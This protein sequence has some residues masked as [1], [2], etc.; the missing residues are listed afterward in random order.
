MRYA[1]PKVA[2]RQAFGT[3]G[4]TLMESGTYGK[5]IQKLDSGEPFLGGNDS[6]GGIPIADVLATAGLDFACLD[7]MFCAFDWQ[8][9]QA[10]ARAALAGGMDPVIRLPSFPWI[11]GS[12]DHVF[13]EAARAFGIGMNGVCLSLNTPDQ[14]ARL[15]EIS[16]AWQKNIHVHPFN[17]TTFEAYKMQTAHSNV[18]IPLLESETAIQAFDEIMAVE[19]LRAACIGLSDLSRVM[20]VPF[21]YEHPKVWDFVERAVN[22]GDRHGVAICAN[23]GYEFSRDLTTLHARIGRM[24]EHGIRGIWLQ[25]TGYLVQWLY[26][27][28]VAQPQ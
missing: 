15:V 11:D 13:A 12:D 25:N 14:V 9:A 1:V 3:K 21:Q 28:I 18:A 26:R 27:R 24:H 7:T 16:R 8:S 23:P 20:G 22:L 10:W 4:Q 6:L 17:E 2:L 19:G 5:F